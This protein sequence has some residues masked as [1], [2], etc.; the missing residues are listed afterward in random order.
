MTGK[1]QMFISRN[2]NKQKKKAKS[3]RE[4]Y[5]CFFTK[6]WKQKDIYRLHILVSKIINKFLQ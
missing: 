3:Q 4:A 6:S 1:K 2:K 5:Y